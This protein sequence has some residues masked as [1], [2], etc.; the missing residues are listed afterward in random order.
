MKWIL[1]EKTTE[2]LKQNGSVLWISS[3]MFKAKRPFG[4]DQLVEQENLEN[5]YENQMELGWE[6]QKLICSA[7]W[8]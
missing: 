2:H 1:G 3:R 4:T 8:T 6:S 7:F 5:S